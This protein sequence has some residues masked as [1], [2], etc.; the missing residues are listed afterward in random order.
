MS[1][2]P[3]ICVALIALLIS[4]SSRRRP[5]RGHRYMIVRIRAVTLPSA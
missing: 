4:S 5:R 1:M 3:L 2:L